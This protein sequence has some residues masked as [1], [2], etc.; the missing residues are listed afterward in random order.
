MNNEPITNPF[1]KLRILSVSKDNQIVLHIDTSNNQEICVG[2]SISGKKQ[3]IREQVGKQK[4]Q[5]VLPQLLSLL[6]KNQLTFSDVTGVTVNIGPGS[7]TGL[8]VGVAIA[9]TLGTLLQ[10]PIN[11]LLIGQLVEPQYT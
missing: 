11:G 2:I 5:V 3:E 9:N 7:F 4:A 6:E 1:D 10:V 8:R